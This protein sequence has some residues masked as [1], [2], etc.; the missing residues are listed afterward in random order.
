MY[1]RRQRIDQHPRALA[2][3]HQVVLGLGMLDVEFIL[4]AEQPPPST[5]TRTW[6]PSA[7]L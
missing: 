5:E 3:Q 7:L 4:E 1:C 2:R 6:R